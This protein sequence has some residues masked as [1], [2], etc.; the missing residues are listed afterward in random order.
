MAH[1]KTLAAAIL[2]VGCIS[3]AH[4]E[5]R[6]YHA[7]AMFGLNGPVKE[8]VKTSPSVDTSAPTLETVD[9][10]FKPNGQMEDESC[11]YN[12]AGYPVSV[13]IDDPN[14]DGTVTVE[15]SADNRCSQYVMEI[16]KPMAMTI[17]TTNEYRDGKLVSSTLT[18]LLKDP[19]LA[20]M[21]PGGMPPFNLEYSNME[22]DSYGNWVK[23]DLKMTF[24]DS[25]I[26][27]TDT[28]VITETRTITYY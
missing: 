7:P 26:A 13:K 28:P 22:Y 2:S 21:I 4:A 1:F 19:A 11:R 12:E 3:L 25:R 9:M 14:F 18:P 27:M 8:V 15:Y 5:E 23:R 6:T 16:D 24:P 10:R 20:E 17:T